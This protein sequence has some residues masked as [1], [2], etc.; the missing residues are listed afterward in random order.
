MVAIIR[1]PARADKGA[2]LNRA[3]MVQAVAEQA[4][5]TAAKAAQAV[6]AVFDCI[7]SALRDGRE[8]RL[9]G[10]GS[11]AVTR[12]KATTGRNP[13]TGAAIEIGPSI[14]VKFKPGRSLKEAVGE[15]G[16]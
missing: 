3:G 12:R 10:F 9:S 2:P 7:Q 1:R 15:E 13:R 6:D 11:F 4:D 14:S 8:A 5:L 16:G